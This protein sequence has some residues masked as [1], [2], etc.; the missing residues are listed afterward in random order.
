MDPGPDRGTLGIRLLLTLVALAACGAALL[1]TATPLHEPALVAVPL[2]LLLNLALGAWLLRGRPHI[3]RLVW[4]LS[5]DIALVG[6]GVALLPAVLDAERVT[7]VAGYLVATLVAAAG[8]RR[9][10]AVSGAAAGAMVCLLGIGLMLQQRI[11]TPDLFTAASRVLVVIVAAVEVAWVSA[12]LQ[13][14]AHRR[15]TQQLVARELKSR[16]AEADEML[17]FAQSLAGS[18]GPHEVLEVFLNHLRRFF[19][20]QAHAVAL[21]ADGEMLATWEEHGRIE[22]VHVAPRRDRLQQ[23]LTEAGHGGTI[24]RLSTRSLGAEAAPVAPPHGAWV[25][26]PLKVQDAVVGVVL[27]SGTQQAALPPGRVG[28]LADLV[29]RA[30]EALARIARARGEE[31][32]RTT[33]LLRQMREGVLLLGPEGKA[34]LANP[35]ARQALSMEREGSALPERLGD[36]ALSELA[37]TPAGVARHFRAQ[38]AQGDAGHPV[39]LSGTAVGILEGKKRIGTLVTLRDVTEEELARR[40]LVQ[41]EKLTLV[42]QT[43]AG[44]AHELNN[45]LAALVGYADLLALGSVPEPL[46]RPIQQMRDQAVRATRIVRNLLNFARRHNPQ[47]VNVQ[48]AELV[49]GAVELLAYEARMHGVT[50]DVA[51]QPQMPSLLADPHALQ[52][53]LVNLVQ[54]AIHALATSERAPRRITIRTQIVGEALALTVADNGPGVPPAVAPRIFEPF[55]TTKAEGHGT[56][57]GLALARAV[58][59]EHGGDLVLE[60][61]RPEGACFSLR[62]PLR[63]PQAT[64]GNAP[65]LSTPLRLPASVLVVDDEMSVRESLVGQ[66]GALGVRAES[67]A[68][69]QEAQRMISRGRYEAL[70]VDVRMPGGSGL[71]LHDQLVVTD[72]SLARRVVFMTGDI[73]NDNVLSSLRQTGNPYLEK[74]FT[75]SELRHALG[76]A[77]ARAER[78]SGAPSPADHAAGV[79]S[80]FNSTV[81]G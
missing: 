54:N 38:V 63:T 32:R 23:A 5:V 14:E 56:G 46:K 21:E 22:S 77:L 31:T 33:M 41:A 71:E 7:F 40:R 67:A 2:A 76:T 55:F 3:G 28:A 72:P 78:A 37:R 62:L 9:G 43:L 75:I 45:P 26:L 13:A 80:W 34:L 30:G 12:A 61:D 68:D 48:M 16:D 15:L 59:R 66:L 64:P 69:M 4:V 44:V 8:R 1:R 39:E 81:T 47:R 17:V 36:V 35:A 70:L 57:L 11:S 74:P 6:F 42:G 27:L 60:T 20:A 53:I 58:A 73:I 29:R 25:A 49:H 79:R 52:Q 51:L 18:E 65:E 24:G 19:E 10:A 50:V